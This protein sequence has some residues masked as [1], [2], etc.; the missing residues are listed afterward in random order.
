MLWSTPD[1]TTE[2]ACWSACR[3]TCYVSSSRSW[4]QPPVW[5]ISWELAIMRY[6]NLLLTLT[7][8][9]TTPLTH[10]SVST[11]CGLQNRYCTKWLFWHTRLCI[12]ARWEYRTQ[13]IAKNSPSAHHRTTLSSYIF[14]TEACI[15]NRKNLLNS[16][17]SPSCPYSMVN[18]S[19]LAAEIVSLVWGT[20][21]TF[22]GFRFLAS[23]LH[24]TQ[25][26]GVSQT[27]RRWIEGAT[28]IPRGGHHVWH[29]P[30]F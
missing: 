30:T 11:G 20:P 1:W 10:L 17:T 28:Y 27:L 24:G 16:N 9:V 7:L 29:W 13:K 22:N 14:A 2:I 5:C 23:L 4:T 3:L 6:I 25:V 12:E 8:R 26:V 19:P 21:A 18:F 15:D